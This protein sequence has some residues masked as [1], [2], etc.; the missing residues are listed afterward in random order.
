M[1]LSHECGGA[2]AR[3]FRVMFFFVF[4]IAPVEG[5][6]VSSSSTA[7]ASSIGGTSTICA[8][9][10]PSRPPSDSRTVATCIFNSRTRSANCF[11]AASP[12]AK[13]CSRP[14]RPPM[15]MSL[16]CT[17]S[18]ASSLGLTVAASIALEMCC[19]CIEHSSSSHLNVRRV[20]RARSTGFSFAPLA[21]ADNAAR[22]ASMHFGSFIPM[23]R[24]TSSYASS[25]S[26]KCRGSIP[27]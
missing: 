25:S 18:A 1:D 4:G 23:P 9:S 5:A 14:I 12:G 21:S 2:I 19:S 24:R 6:G 16:D 22:N 26:S 20:M 17:L 15:C 7:G 27:L 13:S 10:P 11:V 8:P 3:P